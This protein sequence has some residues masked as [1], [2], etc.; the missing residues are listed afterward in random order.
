MSKK[1]TSRVLCLL[2]AFV[3][4]LGMAP[5]A[6]AASHDV[7]LTQTSPNTNKLSAA[8]QQNKIKQLNGEAAYADSDTVRAIVIFDGEAAVPAMLKSRNGIAT[9]SRVAAKARSI[10]SQHARVKTAIEQE[11]VNY[12]VKYEYTTLLNGMSVDVKFGDL[13][14]LANTA[15]VKKVYLANHYDAPIVEKPSMD[16]S[17]KMTRT[18]LLHQWNSGKGTVVAIIDTGITPGHEAFEVY[19][20]MMDEAVLRRDGRECIDTRRRSVPVGKDPVRL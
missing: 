14:K 10:A 3:M 15:G 20:N 11:A 12:D 13:E 19:D 4:V 18:A 16:S 5:M 17:N 7:K 6:A 8:I 2:L 1:T 9:Q